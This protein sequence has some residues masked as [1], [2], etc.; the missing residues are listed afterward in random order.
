MKTALLTPC[1]LEG[2]DLYG[3]NRLKRMERWL[4]YHLAIKDQLGADDFWLLDNESPRS[5]VFD[6]LNQYTSINVLSDWHLPKRGNGNGVDY[7]Y[8]WR[9]IW[10]MRTLITKKDYK[11]IIFLDNDAYIL[12]HRLAKLVKELDSGWSSFYIP[13]YSFN[14]AEFHILCE[15]RFEDFLE[16]TSGNFMDK[17]GITMEKDLPFTTVWK[18]FVGDRY[19]ED[20]D[21]YPQTDEMDFYCQAHLSVPLK[22]HDNQ[23]RDTDAFEA[24]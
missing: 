22:F 12:S 8:C 5:S 15:N 20:I 6:L 23:K 3:N 11:K 19:G 4:D 9:A 18:S 21:K 7:D 14:S 1:Y 16:Y 2:E 17:N 24:V 13:K 10:F